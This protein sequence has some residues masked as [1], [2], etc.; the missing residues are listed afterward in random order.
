M[1]NRGRRIDDLPRVLVL[2]PGPACTPQPPPPSSRLVRVDL[3][4]SERSGLS[5]GK[6]ELLLPP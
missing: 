6:M 2:D 4:L 5:L 1:A 3:L